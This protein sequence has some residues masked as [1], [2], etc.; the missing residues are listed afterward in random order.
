M[1]IKKTIELED[2]SFEINGVFTPEEVDVI[3]EVGLN[4]LYATGALPMKRI[5]KSE[6]AKFQQFNGTEN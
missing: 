3:I 5:H 4:S 2:G 6:A 1:K